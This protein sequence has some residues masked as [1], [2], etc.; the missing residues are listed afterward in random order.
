MDKTILRMQKI[1][2]SF[3]HVQVLF[4][5]DFELKAGEIKGL[6]GENGAGKS[7]LMKIL[8]GEYLKDSGQI[9]LFGRKEEITTPQ[10]ALKLG[11]GMVYQELNN[12]PDMTIAEN[13]FI[14]REISKFGFLG[15][16]EMDRRAVEYLKKLNLS[17]APSQKIGG[18][19]V[20]EMQ[21]V[22]IAKVV[23]YGSKIIV[24]DEPTSSITQDG[25]EKL[26]EVIRILQDMG[27]GIIYISHKLD[28]LFEL[29]DSI[30]VMRDGHM[31][32][33][34]RTEEITQD[35]LIRQMVGREVNDI[36][37]QKDSHPGDVM[38]RVDH[39]TR[40]GEFRDISFAVH[41][42]EVVAFA[43]L[44]G[45][46]RTETMMSLFGERKPESGEVEVF[47]K[48]TA[49]L[50]PMAAVR[51]KMSL[52]PEDRKRHGLNLL[53][54][55]EDNIEIVVEKR[56]GFGKLFV[57]MR[58][59]KEDGRRMIE[60]LAIKCNGPGQ[61]VL[62]LSGGNQQKIV[63]AKWLLSDADIFIL[64]E[65]TRGID[66]GAKIEIYKLIRRLAQEGKAIVLISSELNEV[67][68]L[69]DRVIVMCEGRITGELSGE[70][71]NQET[72]MY[73]GHLY[74]KGVK[75]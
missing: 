6:I 33:V 71:I 10:N 69:S 38:L 1:S 21:M 12:A 8:T 27:I 50:S 56:N 49:I 44:V 65:P 13:M 29:T 55:V 24:L 64:D 25:V 63:L 19:T 23:S 70:D 45:A 35:E 46:G 75:S 22:E 73:Y 52:I 59:K 72:I 60:E 61:Q 57:N 39:F 14:G 66:I 30:A 36:F 67:I 17:F 74:D 5:V 18:L 42:G 32:G 2:K 51:N 41:A 15:K 3:N 53:G 9:E 20:S 40:E 16:K 43:G 26:F 28:E 47:G 4:D 68:G 11:I 48:K 62:S 54:S 7:T 31:V 37:P 58:Q 34:A